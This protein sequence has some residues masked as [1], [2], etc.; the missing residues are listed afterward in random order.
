[1]EKG[2]AKRRAFIIE[3]FSCI[4]SQDAAR[5]IMVDMNLGE[6]VKNEFEV[7]DSIINGELRPF[8]SKYSSEETIEKLI[9]EKNA[10]IIVMNEFGEACGATEKEEKKFNKL[11][12]MPQRII[13]KFDDEYGKYFATDKYD[14]NG[15]LEQLIDIDIPPPLN[16]K[17]VYF[18]IIIEDEY[19]FIKK[20]AQKLLSESSNIE[21][22]VFFA[23]KRI[24]QLKLLAKQAHLLSKKLPSHSKNLREPTDYYVI[25]ILKTYLI[26]SILF[27]QDAF[28]PFLKI[29]ILDEYELKEI[30]YEM[31]SVE[32]IRINAIAMK[33]DK[34]VKDL[35]KEFETLFYCSVKLSLQFLKN[36]YKD[37]DWQTKIVNKALKKSFIGLRQ[38]SLILAAE[39]KYLC[40]SNYQKL[41]ENFVTAAN[42]RLGYYSLPDT[43]NS[44][45]FDDRL[46]MWEIIIDSWTFNNYQPC[47]SYLK[48]NLSYLPLFNYSSKE[49]DLKRVSSERRYKKNDTEKNKIK[50]IGNRS[51]NL[52]PKFIKIEDLQNYFL[53]VIGLPLPSSLFQICNKTIYSIDEEKNLRPSQKA[54]FECRKV[55]KSKWK[56]NHQITIARMIEDDDI[57]QASKKKDG[58]LYTEKTVRDW[59]KDL[60]PNRSPGRPSKN[61][62]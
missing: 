53:N 12:S 31:P 37:R 56:D 11:I 2:I 46:R 40:E 55:A 21:N 60:C 30:L 58:N 33:H 36:K 16:L 15:K 10:I 9:Q 19:E 14:S 59:I 45:N 39:N 4:S 3:R 48:P 7:F 18:L 8:L 13:F 5:G 43:L 1:V 22:V 47:L 29:K 28:T 54:R 20:N 44:D 24:Q 38:L 27:Y 34:F 51:L 17:S 6:N 52:K 42:E 25:S 26:R 61:K 23:E 50:T 35:G 32:S 41:T 49:N 62:K 57:V